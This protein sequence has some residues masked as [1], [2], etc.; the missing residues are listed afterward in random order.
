MALISSQ[1]IEIVAAADLVWRV[2]T[3]VENADKFISGIKRVDIITPA[4][5]P[6]I[7]GLKWRETREFMGKDALETI[8]V[9]EASPPQFYATR[10]ESHG[11]VYHSKITLTPISE[12][13]RLTMDFHCQ[14]ISWPAKIMWVLTSWMAKKSLG[15]I[16]IQDLEDIKVAVEHRML[17]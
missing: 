15:N 11:S 17:P 5:G 4:D 13:T 14:P 1:S 8:W 9:T 6:N 16:I 12:G 3:D 10:A 7:V 2:V